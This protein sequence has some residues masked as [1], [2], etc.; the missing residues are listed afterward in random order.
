MVHHSSCRAVCGPAVNAGRA[1][2][3]ALCALFVVG[4]L[5]PAL[6]GAAWSA[7]VNVSPAAQNALD[8]Q[9]AVDADGDAVFAWRRFD[10]TNTR[11]YGRARSEAGNLGAVQTLSGAGHAFQPQVAVDADGDAVFAWRHFDGANWRIQVRARSAAGTLS[12]V[13]TLSAA[14]GG[15]LGC[16]LSPSTPMATRWSAGPA[17]TGRIT[18]RRPARGRPS[19]P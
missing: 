16:S 15:R 9:V 5:V 6:A 8:A 11:I 18:A 4:L 17:S 14:G 1:L 19:G 2:P 7:P 10:G 12:A 13:Q 3:A